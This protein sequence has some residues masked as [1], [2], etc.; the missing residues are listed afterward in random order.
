MEQNRS[1]N[2]IRKR[3]LNL[4]HKVKWIFKVSLHCTEYCGALYDRV[5][6]F[7]SFAELPCLAEYVDGLWYRAKLLSIT[8][9][10]PVQILV[11][12]VDYGTYLVAPTSR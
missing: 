9:L 3:R 1:T 5:F 2:L 12:F 11:Q 10:V 8:Q 7:L 4:G 6:F